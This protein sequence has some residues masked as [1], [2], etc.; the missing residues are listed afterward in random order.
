MPDSNNKANNNA[1]LPR[2]SG[3]SWFGLAPVG[4]ADTITGTATMP[5]AMAA[6]RPLAGPGLGKTTVHLAVATSG[7]L[8]GPGLGTTTVPL[9]VA[10][11]EP[12]AGS[13]L[14]TAT[15]PLD[16]AASGPLAGPGLGRDSEKGNGR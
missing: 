12:L 11:S 2:L 3:W 1:D 15:I 8:A 10:A 14:E 16:V 9:A 4:D 13:G 6:S 7:P 5:L